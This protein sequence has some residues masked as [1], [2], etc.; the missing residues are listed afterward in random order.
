MNTTSVRVEVYRSFV[1]D[2]RAPTSA[3]IATRLRLSPDEVDASLRQL[4]EDDVV[5]LVPGTNLIWLAHPFCAL[6]APFHVK[7]GERTWDGICIWDALGIL[8]MLELDGEVSTRCPH[9]G[10]R[11]R[12]EVRDGALVGQ[13]DNVV[14]FGVP[15][16]RWYED[17]GYT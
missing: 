12:L 7:S 15:A 14:H 10:E 1:E 5:A 11:L 13:E 17:V 16:S 6:D 9:C 8:A 3:D 4:H 2:G